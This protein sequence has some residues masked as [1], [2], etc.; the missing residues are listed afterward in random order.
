MVKEGRAGA[1]K[2]NQML[3]GVLN[4]KKNKTTTPASAATK[5]TSV[6]ILTLLL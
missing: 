3:N 1:N 5:C 6:I 4:S 2:R